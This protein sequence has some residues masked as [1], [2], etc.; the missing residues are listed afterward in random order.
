ML[1]IL[2][3]VC[4]DDD[5]LSGRGKREKKG[6]NCAYL[7]PGSF[8]CLIRWSESMGY[9]CEIVCTHGR[10]ILELRWWAL[11]INHD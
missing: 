1:G 7:L 11:K 4:M 9:A 5:S 3:N 10:R 8:L 2:C 6:E